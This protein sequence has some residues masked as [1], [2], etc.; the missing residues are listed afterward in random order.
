MFEASVGL[1]T[2]GVQRL[3]AGWR[4]GG[5]VCD[6]LSWPLR[7]RRHQTGCTYICL[8]RYGVGRQMFVAD[9]AVEVVGG[10]MQFR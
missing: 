3:E 6:D 1:T 9:D 5:L 7:I 8:T 2:Y 4:F 10:E